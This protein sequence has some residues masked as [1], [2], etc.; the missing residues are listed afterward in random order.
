[1]S[2]AVVAA[3]AVDAAAVPAADDAGAALAAADDAG[4]ALAAADDAAGCAV[5]LQ[6]PARILAVIATDSN[7]AITFFL[8]TFDLPILSF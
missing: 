7:V 2:P 8:I 3:A 6:H 4:A 5:L 1:M